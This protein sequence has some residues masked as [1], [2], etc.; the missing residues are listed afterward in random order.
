MKSFRFWVPG[1]LPGENEIIKACRS[2][3]YPRLK[4][5]WTSDIVWCIKA[6]IPPKGMARVRCDFEWVSVDKRHDPDNIE[7][8]QKFVWDSLSA[9]RNGKPG[10]GVIPNDGWA[11]NAGSS[12]RHVVGPRAGVWVTVTEAP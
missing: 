2:R 12:H 7:A 1:P 6:A 10:A 11:Q 4:V 5:K 3:A 8:G 9:P